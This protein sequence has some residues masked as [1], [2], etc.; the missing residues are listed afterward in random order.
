MK[1]K[2]QMSKITT[3]DLVMIAN[4]EG[5][6]ILFGHWNEFPLG[7]ILPYLDRKVKQVYQQKTSLGPCI[8]IR[9]RGNGEKK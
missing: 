3:I 1:L 8:T 7:K 5:K 4:E 9:L 6:E 2:E